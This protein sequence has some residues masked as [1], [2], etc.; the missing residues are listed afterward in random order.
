MSTVY[1][2][3]IEKLIEAA[4]AD[5]VL[6]DQERR[7]LINNANN[8]GY[9]LDEFEMYVNSKLFEA[10]Q[11]LKATAPKSNKVG[12]IKKCPNCG[13]TVDTAMVKC[14][15]CG[16]NFSDVEANSSSERLAELLRN[17]T[18]FESASIVLNFPVPTSKA[19][20]IEFMSTMLSRAKGCSIDEEELESAYRAKFEE[21]ANKAHIYFENDPDFER[22]FEQEKKSNTWWE[23]LTKKK[24]N[25]IKK[26]TGCLGGCLGLFLLFFVIPGIIMCESGK[27]TEKND[28]DAEYNDSVNFEK[29]KDDYTSILDETQVLIKD[30]KLSSAKTKLINIDVPSFHGDEYSFDVNPYYNK[31]ASF[32]DPTFAMLV[33]AYIIK[34]DYESAKNVGKIFEGKAGS[35]SYNSTMTDKLL[36]KY[37][38]S[39][40]TS[41]NSQN[42]NNNEDNEVENNNQTAMQTEDV[43]QNKN[44]GENYSD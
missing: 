28:K 37:E 35:D 12:E 33:E 9:D 22:L 18:S 44:D 25:K 15:E 38:E 7:V 39:D 29:F 31:V 14:P 20:L 16:Y 32:L 2:S 21:C 4:V 8:Y 1:D 42:S 41:Y 5:G 36:E 40:K 17:N 23:K 13:A 19:D 3:R 34:K 30:G 11:R 26:R 27:N 24:R 10:Q 43:N 6:T